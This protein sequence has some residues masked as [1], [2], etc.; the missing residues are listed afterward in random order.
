MTASESIR[1]H[2][3]HSKLAQPRPQDEQLTR[4]DLDAI[5][6]PGSR[7]AGYLDHAV[8]L[9]DAADCWLV[10]LSSGRLNSLEARTFLDSR[11]Y[12][13][14]IVVDLP[15]EY[16]HELLHFP[17][18]LAIKSELPKAIEYYTTDLSMKRNIGLLLARMLRWRRIFFLDD[19]I[20]IA[21][22][23]LRRTVDML[24]AYSAA[25]MVVTNFPDNS[26]VCHAN[27]MT[28]G[29]QGVFVSGAALAV[30]CTAD[31]GFFPDIYN[32][33]WLFFFDYASK[34]RLAS[35]GLDARQLTYY[36]FAR[37]WRAAWQ[38]FGD[39]IAEGLYTLLHLGREIDEATREYWADFLEARRIFLEAI[40]TR[41]ETI[42][43][44]PHAHPDMR[45]EMQRSVRAAV[46]CLLTIEPD[47]CV[48]YIQAWRQDLANWKRQ[49]TGIT[50]APS[51][52]A[53]LRELRLAPTTAASTDGRALIHRGEA[54]TTGAAG[55]VMPQLDTWKE[56]FERSGTPH[57]GSATL[58][59]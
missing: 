34:G 57:A 13:K 45:E 55:P 43:H 52:E 58:G 32:E 30:E 53:A 12:R 3:F 41:S 49:V 51:I 59:G 7:P 19:D 46:K 31:I 11:P 10:I 17:R 18:L 9:A 33:D 54:V 35:S 15:S 1:Q 25:G 48:R 24:G 47:L 40:I 21:P 16:S 27:R 44:P 14:A 4:L 20:Y 29:S 36:P 38:E 37:P 39:V 26:I 23:S 50:A 6:V 42:T 28:G 22:P 5:I 2:E 8:T 56:M